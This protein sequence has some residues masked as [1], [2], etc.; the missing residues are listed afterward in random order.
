MGRPGSMEMLAGSN[1][2]G[3]RSIK[4]GVAPETPRGSKTL[5]VTTP[6]YNK[7]LKTHG[8]HPKAPGVQ[9]ARIQ[10]AEDTKS[11]QVRF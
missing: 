6:G 2:P 3:V 4:S 11:A 10:D 1:N 5:P 7:A 9:N 8:V